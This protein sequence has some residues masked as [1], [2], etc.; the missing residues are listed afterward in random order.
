MSEN[1]G[2]KKKFWSGLLCGLLLACL[3]F[4]GIYI[5]TQIYVEHRYQA[6]QKTDASPENTVIN[7]GS[8]H[9]IQSIQSVI[10]Q[11][12]LEK[13]ETEALENGLYEGMLEALGDPYSRYYSAEELSEFSMQA[14]GIYY[15]IG[16]YIGTDT[17]TGLPMIAGTIEGTPAAASGLQ[18][19]DLLCQVDGTSV[20]GMENTDVVALIHGEEGTTVRL[21]IYRAG[22]SDYRDFDIERKKIE[23]PTVNQKMYDDGIAY[24]QITEFDNVTVDQF[25]EA[26]AVCK[27]SN[28][29]GLILDLRNNPGGNVSAVT[30][31]ARQILPQGL[32][33]YTEDKSGNR[34]EYTCDGAHE[35]QVPMVVL[36]NGGSASSSEILAGAIKDYG[37]GTL[38]GTTTYGKGIV[39]R[40]I[41]LAD[42]SALKLTVSKYYT[43]KGN[44]IHKI[45]IEPD[46][47]LKF[48][49]DLYLKDGTD[50]QLERA[51]EILKE[52]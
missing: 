26:L 40:V 12:F 37:K 25:T 34:D 28:M 51:K 14:Q 19:G 52:K 48:D 18:Y 42:G 9:K 3:V 39:Q 5:G 22:E 32:I 41:P 35:L 47:E 44:N 27:G 24:I 29:K 36:V 31:I 11:Y 16:A 46:E 20:E 21:T 6:A 8:I 45:G 17:A 2:E 4:G 50:N 43:P 30:E 1:M 7:A 38:L 49:G 33:V 23:S 15:G 10:D 13:P